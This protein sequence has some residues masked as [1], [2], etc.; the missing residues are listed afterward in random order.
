MHDAHVN[1]QLTICDAELS[2][3]DLVHLYVILM[4]SLWVIHDRQF[5]LCSCCFQ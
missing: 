4:V 3:C 2:S 1:C 5:D